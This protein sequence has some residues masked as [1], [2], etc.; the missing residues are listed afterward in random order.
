MA[1]ILTKEEI[2]VKSSFIEDIILDKA[3]PIYLDYSEFEKGEKYI[4]NEKAEPCSLLCV[5][6]SITNAN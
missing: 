5:I 3:Y 6:G 2:I 4:Y 1:N